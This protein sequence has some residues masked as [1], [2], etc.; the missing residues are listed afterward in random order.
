MV[1]T[2]VGARCPDCARLQRA[3]TFQVSAR[4]Y[5]IAAGVGLGVALLLG[6]G[7]SLVNLMVSFFYLNLAVAAGVGWLIGELISR[8]VNRK[9]SVAL[10]VIAAAAVV[11][12]YLVGTF[13]FPW[14]WQVFHLFD[15][16]ALALGIYFAVN[17]V[18]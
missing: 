5:L 3:P 9:R 2:P 15:L 4:H 1:Q 11:V 8:S 14:G 18:R 6:L 16:L 7:W 12:S 10:A 13:L 17:R